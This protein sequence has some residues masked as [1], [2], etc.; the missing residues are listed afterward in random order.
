MLVSI[1]SFVVDYLLFNLLYYIV[2]GHTAASTVLARVASSLFNFTL[3]KKLVFTDSEKK[4]NIVNYYKLA[5]VI[6]I[7]NMT[8]ISVLVNL[9]H[10]PAFIAKII[11]EGIL[12]IVSFTV[13]NKWSKT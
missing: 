11:V 2:L 13:Q 7:C 10:V 6:L 9:L 5:A 4:Y 8:F 12:Y 1:A 3:N